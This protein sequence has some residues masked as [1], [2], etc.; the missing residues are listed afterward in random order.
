MMNDDPFL[1]AI[2][3]I[4]SFHIKTAEQSSSLQS[5]VII[6]IIIIINYFNMFNRVSVLVILALQ[7]VQGQDVCTS[8]WK[9]DTFILEPTFI[10]FANATKLCTAVLDDMNALAADGILDAS[11]DCKNAQLE[12]FQLGCCP[13]APKLYCT[14]CPDGTPHER[15]TVVPINGD[16][17]D[18]SC[19]VSQVREAS[20]NGFFETGSCP[21]TILQRGAFYCGCPNTE[22]QC[23]LCP[24]GGEPPNKRKVDA[25]QTESNCQGNDYL[26]SL[27]TADE[28]TNVLP[29]QGIDFS[30]FCECPGYVMP[31]SDYVCDLCPEGEYV[32][33]LSK[34]HTATD[35]AYERTCGQAQD[36]TEFVIN[37]IICDQNMEEAREACCVPSGATSAMGT[38]L[39][40]MLAVGIVLVKSFF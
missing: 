35:A 26:F 3:R 23:F 1:P 18:P 28:C 9:E 2:M 6:I 31:E 10:F 39:S 33:N 11:G 32:P 19:E 40:L 14:I 16:A 27:F 22:Q 4:S 34:V 8:C 21:D 38:A 24:N 25:Y 7:V 13:R 15:L 12:A 37:P 17:N 20:L 5:I 29:N 30:A 36:F